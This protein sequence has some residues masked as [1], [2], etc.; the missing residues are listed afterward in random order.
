MRSRYSAYALGGLGQYLIDTWHPSARADLDPIEL[1][2][3]GQNW[4]GLEIVSASQQGD[5]AEVEFKARFEDADGVTQLH[6]ERST[7]SRIEGK[8]LY[9]S[10]DV[11]SP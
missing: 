9:L 4:L 8:W 2:K 6:H 7:F 1:S 10:G 11:F 5:S 3:P